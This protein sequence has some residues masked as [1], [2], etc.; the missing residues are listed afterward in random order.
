MTH[1]CIK[2][3]TLWMH[4]KM[5]LTHTYMHSR[6]D[7]MN[8]YEITLTHIYI[9]WY[10]TWMHMNF[11]REGRGKAGV[12]KNAHICIERHTTR[13]HMCIQ[14][15]ITWMYKHRHSHSHVFKG[16][17]H[18]C[19]N[20]TSQSQAVVLPLPFAFWPERKEKKTESERD[21]MAGF[22]FPSPR[23]QAWANFLLCV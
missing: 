15:R 4:I 10:T 19:M 23:T 14:G 3:Y 18:E 6:L 5:T 11:Y 9:K 1:I 7:C 22:M 17:L 8:S 21:R 2:D 12:H 20:H 16:I 13:T